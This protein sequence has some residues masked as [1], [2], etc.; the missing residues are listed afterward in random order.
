MI[1]LHRNKLCAEPHSSHNL[2]NSIKWL[3]VKN[4]LKLVGSE[5]LLKLKIGIS[6]QAFKSNKIAKLE[7]SMNQQGIILHNFA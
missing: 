1:S 5:N 3:K 4:Y 6:T 2:K 7:L